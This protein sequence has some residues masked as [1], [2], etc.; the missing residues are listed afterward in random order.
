[1][2]ILGLAHDGCKMDASSVL[3]TSVKSAQACVASLH[4]KEVHGATLWARQLG[5]EWW[6][7]MLGS[8]L[9]FKSFLEMPEG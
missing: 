3:F 2:N 4:Q 7:E 8:V 5:G 1:M 6:Y 9:K